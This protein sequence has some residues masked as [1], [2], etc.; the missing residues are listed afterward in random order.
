MKR[1]V[2]CERDAYFRWTWIARVSLSDLRIDGGRRVIFF[3][4]HRQNET[5]VRVTK[6]DV[7]PQILNQVAENQ[8]REN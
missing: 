4:I 1:I 8:R 6:Q 7:T 2:Q 3:P 5:I